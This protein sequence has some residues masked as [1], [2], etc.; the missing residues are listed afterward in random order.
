[1]KAKVIQLPSRLRRTRRPRTR[2][3]QAARRHDGWSAC[4]FK[5]G[6]SSRPQRAGAEGG[7]R[8]APGVPAPRL[9]R[10]RR[11]GEAPGAARRGGAGGS[12]GRCGRCGLESLERTVRGARGDEPGA[13]GGLVLPSVSP[14]S[15]VCP[16]QYTGEKR[17]QVYRQRLRVWSS[18]GERKCLVL[19]KG[20]YCPSN[21]RSLKKRDQD[22]CFYQGL[23]GSEN[24]SDA[25]AGAGTANH[26]QRILCYAKK[27]SA[28]CNVGDGEPP[29]ASWNHRNY[30]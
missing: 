27:S 23:A 12:W 2:R 28:F 5:S 14:Y 10:G 7:A 6:S 11:S 15:A 16:A 1:M 18:G 4:L 13:G 24:L 26:Q 29:R 20:T 8:A 21:L 22:G 9:P 30:F 25:G 17:R 19:P 3:P